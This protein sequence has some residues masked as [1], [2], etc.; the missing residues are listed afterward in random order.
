MEALKP[1]WTIARSQEIRLMEWDEFDF[2][3]KASMFPAEKM[4]GEPEPKPQ[5][6]H[7]R[8]SNQL[9]QLGR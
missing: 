3:A 7:A 4:M 2:E 5:I 6:H 1:S 9:P 8:L